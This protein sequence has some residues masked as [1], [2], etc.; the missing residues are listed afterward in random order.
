ME[1]EADTAVR[2]RNL[3]TFEVRPSPVMKCRATRKEKGKVIMT[4]EETSRRDQVP[5]VEARVRVSLEKPAEVLT[6]SLDTEKDP[7]ALEKIAKKVVEGVARETTT[8]QPI[9]SPWTSTG[10]VILETGEDP[11]VEE[12]QSEGVNAADM[13]CG[14]V[15]PLLRYLD[16]KLVKYAGSTNVGS[17]VRLVRNMTRVKVATA[18]RVVEKE[19]QLQETEAK[20]EVLRRR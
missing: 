2:E 8:Q 19:R 15:I 5:L 17:Y 3:Q 1:L 4:E 10:T 16:N 11:S 12:I 13:L 9:T 20:Y 7:M 14:Q 18:H 6:V